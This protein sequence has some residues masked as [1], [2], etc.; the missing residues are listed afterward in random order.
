MD[1]NPRQYALRSIIKNMIIG[2]LARFPFRNRRIDPFG[3]R[4]QIVSELPLSLTYCFSC[5]TTRGGI[6][7][8]KY[9]GESVCDELVKVGLLSDELHAEDNYTIT[10]FGITAYE[11]Y[12]K[13][14]SDSCTYARD[15]VPYMTKELYRL[16]GI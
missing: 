15:I 6:D 11:K 5:D 9:V 3:G 14:R 8:V 10:K 4:D 12:R 2:H 13:E 1:L 7:V 16:M